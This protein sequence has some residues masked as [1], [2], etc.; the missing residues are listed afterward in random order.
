MAHLILLMDSYR[1]ETHLILLVDRRVMELNFK[2]SLK[3]LDD[4]LNIPIFHLLL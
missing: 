2:A 3:P 1:T 4:Q